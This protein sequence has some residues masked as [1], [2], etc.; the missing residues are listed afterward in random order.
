M[1]IY[2]KNIACL[3]CQELVKTE[4]E[5]LG[6]KD[7]VV[8]NGEVNIHQEVS[9][10]K[11]EQLSKALKKSGFEIINPEKAEIVKEIK[12]TIDEL[13]YY[14]E[15]QL[16]DLL[17]GYLRKEYNLEYNHL[18]DL[19]SEVYNTTIEK[20][21]KLVKIEKAKEL[22]VYYRLNLTEISYQLNYNSVAHFTNQFREVTGISPS[23]FL[24][25]K[26]L[27]QYAQQNV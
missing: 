6:L 17:P 24:K 1:T 5:K 4:L 21:F 18:R 26:Y 14:T 2:I 25:I 27:R 23:T 22:L 9:P 8:N 13:V 3:H 11:R 20:Y 15:D 10:F 12:D 16:R 7:S 19:F